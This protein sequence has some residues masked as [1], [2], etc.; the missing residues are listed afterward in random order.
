MTAL[1]S[2]DP[3][4]RSRRP[5]RRLLLAPFTLLVASSAFVVTADEDPPANPLAGL[6]A[7]SIDAPAASPLGP[8]TPSPLDF[9]RSSAGG[10]EQL[11]PADEVFVPTAD[12]DGDG[13]LRVVWSIDDCCYLY[14]KRTTVEIVEE[15]IAAGVPVFAEGLDYEDEFF[16]PSVI[17]RRTLDLRV[18]LEI[19]A[20]R[21]GGSMAVTLGWQGCADI[22]VCYPPQTRTLEVALA[23][24]AAP[25]PSGDPTGSSEGT[26]AWRSEQDV[27]T[28]RLGEAGYGALP[29]FFGLG[30][31]LAFTPCVF[32]MVP[33][34]SGIITADSGATSRRAFGLSSVYVL[35][36]AATYAGFGVLAAVSG[37]NLQAAFQHPAVLVAFAGLFV[38][39]ALSMFGLYEL[40]VP[41]AVRTRLAAASARRRGGQ[42]VSVGAMGMLSALIVGP[43]VAAPLIGVLG[44]IAA[45]GDT[46][47]GG[48]T[49][50]VLALGM[51]TPLLVV[52]TSAGRWLPKSGPWMVAVQ[53][54]FGILL[55][56]VAIWMLERILP[57]ALVMTLWALLALGAG[58]IVLARGLAGRPDGFGVSGVGV[59][60]GRVSALA[61]GALLT[62]YGAVIAVGAGTGALTPLRPL[63]GL[64]AS[65]TASAEFEPV[66]ST[67]ALDERLAAAAAAGR[68]L[69]LEYYADWCVSCKE[70]E[71]YT[72]ADPRVAEALSRFELLQADVTDN[73]A[74]DRAL[75]E[76]FGLV[77]PPAMLFFV[78]GRE[79]E[80]RSHRLVGFVRAEAFLQVLERVEAQ[81][82]RTAAGSSV[83][84]SP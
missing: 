37:A 2:G 11:R 42:V 17:H 47:L 1:P 28:D 65:A 13:A 25:E 69:M 61:V 9:G 3:C 50:F 41:N 16:G 83:A 80:L 62:I 21:A 45:T 30:L 22:G 77:G 75:L 66:A 32:P 44:Y 64:A 68:P 10:G 63:A 43:C 60:G 46:V 4:R 58:G 78:P 14:E 6:R 15:G 84:T 38:A 7:N 74:D 35:A 24:P 53:R 29:L 49:L 20:S 5:G 57:A 54:F 39:L 36:M 33:I 19:D 12:I 71:R 82:G 51:G 31:L 56:G 73:D 59:P 34:L 76:R 72:F 26:A 67:E 23:P 55:L 70:M 18:P 81:V 52:G 79:G 8:E 48:I 27:L 40:Q